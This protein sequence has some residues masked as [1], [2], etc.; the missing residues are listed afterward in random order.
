MKHLKKL[1]LLLAAALCT[2]L[3]DVGDLY[4]S[5]KNGYVGALLPADFRPFNELSPWNIPVSEKAVADSFSDLMINHL[6][7]KAKIL[8]GNITKWTVPVF[9]IDSGTSRKR[10]VKTTADDINPIVDPDRDG[11]A[12]GLPMPEGVWQDPSP[13]GHMTLID[14]K[15][16]KSWDFSRAQ[17]LPGGSWIASRIDTWDLDGP[18]YRKP[19]DGDYWWT[20]GAR[21]SGF[22]LIAGLIR[23]EEIEK[24]E[25]N[26]A[27]VCAT[28]INRKTTYPDGKPQLCSPPASRT[29]GEG[30]GYEYIPEGA[31]LQLDPKLDLDLLNL[32][33]ETKVIAR[34]MQKYGMYNGDNSEDFVIYFQ[35]LGPDGGKWK[36]Y[37]MFSDL[38][39]IPVERFR[40]LK[41]NL[42]S[43]K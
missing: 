20:Y 14:T 43:K 21:G 42:V 31:R 12:Q 35:N 26:H 25:I 40:V 28:P 8:K 32:T 2:W 10:D 9:V 11:V 39:K 13:D 5:G 30:I 36:K 16:G 41:C 6:K 37:G 7:H 19:F 4:A 15:A 33:P 24:G 29:D 17:Q 38:K 3:P 23:P 27:L 18:G 34:A 22:P 1:L